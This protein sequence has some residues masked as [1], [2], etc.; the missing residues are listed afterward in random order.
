MVYITE[1]RVE[2]IE[3][4]FGNIS[5]HIEQPNFSM[6]P[7]H[8]QRIC[9]ELVAKIRETCL[10][11]NKKR[12]V[13]ERIRKEVTVFGRVVVDPPLSIRTITSVSGI[14]YGSVHCILKTIII[15]TPLK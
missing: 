14:N 1:G 8:V 7:T 13:A 5:M 10:A 11:V 12:N 15:S 6:Y 4:F 2:I 3:L 9:F